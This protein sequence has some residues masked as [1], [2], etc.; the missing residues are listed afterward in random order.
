[1]LENSRYRKSFSLGVLKDIPRGYLHTSFQG[2]TKITID[3]KAG[4]VVY[5]G[6]HLRWVRSH[7]FHMAIPR[8]LRP[9][10]RTALRLTLTG[11]TRTQ[12][13]AARVVGIT[14]AYLSTAKRNP[15]M[16]AYIRK[17]EAQ[18]DAGS[19]QMSTVIQELGRKGLVKI[20]LMMESDEV[21]DELRLRAAMD[22]AD[23]S[24][25]TSKTSKLS[26]EGDLTI[27]EGD[28]QRLIQA[29]VEA[30]QADEKYASG[31]LP[32]GLHQS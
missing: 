14:Q 22:L 30:S 6:G 29:L 4:W 32:R 12:A 28:A 13:E 27:R 1:M 18:M 24:P 8:T 15:L 17:I 2:G 31:S 10:V 16:Q 7:Y 3:K 20:A 9:R 26:I 5:W 21:K 11:A 25:E 23:R 19:V